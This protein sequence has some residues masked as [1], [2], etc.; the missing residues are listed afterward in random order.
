MTS[1]VSMLT[2]PDAPG[3]PEPMRGRH[4]GQIQISFLGSAAEGEEL[5]APLRELE[6]MMEQLQKIPYAQSEAVF[7]EPD[8]PHAY[9]GDNLLLSD[10]DTSKLAELTELSAPG[11]P[12]MCVVG[13]RHLGGALSRAPK[14]PNAIGKRSAGYLLGVLSPT[15]PDQ[16]EA[17]RA[18][19]E[20]AL[21]SWSELAVGRLLNFTF[22]ALSPDKI[23][24]AYTPEDYRRL[25]EIKTAVDPQE[26]FRSNF[27]LPTGTVG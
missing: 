17:A 4:I 6:P 11:N 1:A 25:T 8:Q 2:F 26:L 20:E 21:E 7:N 3:V 9:Q 12:M 14:I 22:G 18:M 10:V 16:V 5:V 19:H 15:E 27:P 23:R 24:A 13:L